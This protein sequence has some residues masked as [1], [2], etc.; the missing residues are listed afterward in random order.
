MDQRP[1][2]GAARVLGG[3]DLASGRIDVRQRVIAVLMG[4]KYS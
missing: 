3:D 4:V 1:V 2:V